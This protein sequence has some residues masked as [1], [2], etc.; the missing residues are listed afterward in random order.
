LRHTKGHYSRLKRR[1]APKI[2]L[3]SIELTISSR[4]IFLM[5]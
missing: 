3:R 1:G 4:K 2:C 5:T